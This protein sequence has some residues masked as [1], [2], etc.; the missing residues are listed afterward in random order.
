[1]M[2]I[3]ASYDISDNRRRT[4]VAKILEGF[5]V[6]VQYSVFEC[7][8]SARQLERLEGLLWRVIK[9]EEGDDVRLYF[10]CQGCLPKRMRLGFELTAVR[11]AFYRV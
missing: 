7:D 2:F 11:E 1:M 8:L 3:I 10:L 9:P 6:R 5:G 4:S